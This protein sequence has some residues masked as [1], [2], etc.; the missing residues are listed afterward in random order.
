MNFLG[1]IISKK[2]VEGINGLIL[3]V[4]FGK[5]AF[6]DTEENAEKLAKL[7]VIK[8]WLI[9]MNEYTRFGTTPVEWTQ[10]WLIPVIMYNLVVFNYHS[11]TFD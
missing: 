8:L 10:N 7:M 5:A 4:K 3:D 1:S 6:M 9:Y 2:A 11:Q